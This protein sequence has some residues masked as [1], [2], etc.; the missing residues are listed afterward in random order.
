VEAKTMPARKAKT[1]PSAPVAAIGTPGTLLVHRDLYPN[2]VLFGTAFAFL[3][4]CYVHLDVADDDRVAVRLEP[5][6]GAALSAV[7]LAGEF[8]NELV[9][10]ALRH[11]LSKQTEKVRT[12]IIGRAIGL[13]QPSDAPVAAA[14]PATPQVPD[15]PPEVAKLLAEEDENLDFLDDPLGIAVPWEEKFGKKDGKDAKDAPAGGK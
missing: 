10:Q 3:D 15:L 9:N 5:R 7:D 8:G 6:P 13:A 14:L 12:M 2:D 1:D 11:K 4:R